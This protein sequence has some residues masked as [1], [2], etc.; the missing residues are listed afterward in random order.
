MVISNIDLTVVLSQRPA[1]SLLPKKRYSCAITWVPFCLVIIL[2]SKWW[3]STTTKITLL[4]GSKRSFLIPLPLTTHKVSPSIGWV[5][6]GF[7][8]PLRDTCWQS[9]LVLWQ[10]VRKLGSRS[11]SCPQQIPLGHWSH[12][13]SWCYYRWLGSWWALRR[14]HDWWLAKLG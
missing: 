14:G 7:V 4:T 13:R 10:P 3:F 8:D 6:Y 11:L 9:S 5:T 2:A 1:P 12:W